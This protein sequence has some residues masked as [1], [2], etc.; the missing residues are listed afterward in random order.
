[1][2]A[3]AGSLA[4]D[5][6][7]TATAMFVSAAAMALLSTA[8]L[9]LAVR[10]AAKSA[11]LGAAARTTGR[12]VVATGLAVAL[13][14]AFI[15]TL[16]AG[17]MLNP[18]PMP[19][20]GLVPGVDRSLGP[21][22]GAIVGGFFVPPLMAL[23]LPLPLVAATSPALRPAARAAGKSLMVAA[24]ANA[25]AWLAVAALVSMGLM[26]ASP[27]FVAALGAGAVL[28]VGMAAL[29]ARTALRRAPEDLVMSP[30]RMRLGRATF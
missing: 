30:E 27:W 26:E 24:I 16:Y 22:G 19:D 23:L 17:L 15:V 21:L 2:A 8:Q 18:G 29:V 11:P 12:R 3:R 25:I 14:V 5:L 1:E 7:G 6:R 20:A 10:A 13:P 4:G 28:S 9:S